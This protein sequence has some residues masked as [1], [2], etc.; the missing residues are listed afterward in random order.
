MCGIVAVI[1]RPPRRRPPTGPEILD[2]LA[3]GC[4]R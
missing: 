2:L 3:G 1:S 4:D